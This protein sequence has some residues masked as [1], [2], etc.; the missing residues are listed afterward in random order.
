MLIFS[1]IPIYPLAHERP[2]QRAAPHLYEIVLLLNALLQFARHVRRDPA[3]ELH[4]HVHHVLSAEG[5]N[6]RS[7]AVSTRLLRAAPDS[8]QTNSEE[9]MEFVTGPQTSSE[10]HCSVQTSLTPIHRAETTHE[11]TVQLRRV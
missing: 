11:A 5:A 4:H 3:D 10:A 1:Q 6:T 8:S 9:M 2:A 7:A